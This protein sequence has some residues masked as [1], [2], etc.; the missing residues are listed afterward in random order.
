METISPSSNIDNLKARALIMHDRDD[1]LIPSVESRRLADALA[2]RGDLRYTEVLAFE[3]V[4][5]AGD[6][7]LWLLVKEG[8]KLFRHTYGIIRLS[9]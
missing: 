9:R 6:G 7:N 2:D 8:Y 4:R 5:P 3:H 1:Q